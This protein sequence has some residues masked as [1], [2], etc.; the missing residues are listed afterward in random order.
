M[1]VLTVLMAIVLCVLSL[2]M[3]IVEWGQE[4]SH[5]S[6]FFWL[7]L[8]LINAFSAFSGAL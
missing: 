4:G 2:Y 6:V 1:T 7:L 5:G 8:A 3:A